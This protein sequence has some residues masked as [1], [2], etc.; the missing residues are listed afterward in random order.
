MAAGRLLLPSLMPALDSDGSPIPN[1][2]VFFYNNLTTTLA[3]VYADE[4][5]TTPL[6]NPVEANASGRFPAVWADD[7]VLY[8]ASVEAPYGP[9][10]V[11]FTYDNLSASMAADILVAGAAEAA[12]DEAAQSL[13]DIEAAIQ[14]A[15]DADGSAA[16]A[17][18]I[19]GQAAG[20]AAAN[21]VVA[22][23][24]DT[25]LDN[26][27]D[28]DFGGKSLT[29]S[30]ASVA[31]ALERL[32]GLSV[33]PEL[34]GAAGDGTTSD[35]AALI[36]AANTGLIVDGGGRTYAFTAGFQFPSNTK[37][38]NIRLVRLA[39][40]LSQS[41]NIYI[42]GQTNIHL[43]DVI[44][45]LGGAQQTGSDIIDKNGLQI[46][47]CTDSTFNNVRVVNG[48][49]VTGVLFSG[50]ARI[51]AVDVE[52]A[53]F[54][55]TSASQP[56]DDV[57]QGVF[58]ID[59][60]DSLFV[61]CGGRDLTANWP[62]RPTPWR[63]YSRGFAASGC[64]DCTFDTPYGYDVDQGVDFT[65]STG[66][67]NCS[68]I[69]PQAVD[70]STLGY[71]WANNNTNSV[72]TGGMSVR[73]GR[74]G[75][76][77]NSAAGMGTPYQQN[78]P[79]TG[80]MVYDTG[81]N[82]LYANQRYGF[83]LISST[84]GPDGYPAGITLDGCHS[85]DTQ[86]VKTTDYGFFAEAYDEMSVTSTVPLNTLPN[87]KSFGHITDAVGFSGPA[88][89]WHFSDAKARGSADQAIPNNAF[90]ALTFGTD[91]YDPANLISNSRI[92]IKE[93]GRYI[94]FATVQWTA[95]ATGYRQLQLRMNGT[96]IDTGDRSMDFGTAVENL[97]SRFFAFANCKAG[98]YLEIAGYQNSGGPLFAVMANSRFSVSKLHDLY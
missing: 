3:P 36:A 39:G 64:S 95:N 63:R 44:I 45:D 82:G 27:S 11:P 80:F 98:D 84:L 50:C 83:S 35:N 8:S 70:C 58:A 91:I 68:V 7:T 24:A 34:K 57:C 46:S 97:T 92:Y 43:E 31:L 54:V 88:P 49:S 42:D 76:V 89:G 33:H 6:A 75:F 77:C 9:A 86:A 15:Q 74:V 78:I 16:V 14:A 51:K 93:T 52:A 62:S 47:N 38:R 55:A 85:Y 65:G 13:A 10:G 28:A 20:Q 66:N 59:C 73:A 79:V 2:K 67:K 23:K 18:A 48:G 56:S 61:R 41:K 37:F 53:N 19:A 25:D 87:C 5:L 1:A 60:T 72:S 29:A 21:A 94:V 71:K 69:N 12:A 96:E 90:T 32:T 40:S 81:A 22:N 4:A 26:V 30:G 17:G